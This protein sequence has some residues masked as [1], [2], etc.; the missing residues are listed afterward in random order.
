MALFK[1][2]SDSLW[3]YVSP[4]KPK[5]TI[6]TP[7]IARQ[8]RKPSQVR[9]GS[10]HD[11]VRTSRSMSPVSRVDSWRM[12]P[13]E[14]GAS[15]KRKVL[16]SSSDGHRNKIVKMDDSMDYTP[17]YENAGDSDMIDQ[18]FEAE[19]IDIE[20]ERY[21]GPGAGF[22]VDEESDVGEEQISD[23]VAE[24]ED[25][26]DISADISSIQ[27]S[28]VKSSPPPAR[29]KSLYNDE[30][31]PEADM[32]VVATP[33]EYNRT[34]LFHRRMTTLPNELFSRDATTEKLQAAGWDDDH[35]VLVQKLA[36]RGFEP[37]LPQ[38]WKMDFRYL[39]D[40]LFSKNNKAFI[41]SVHNQHNRGAK[42]LAKLFEIGGRLRDG[43][44]EGSVRS[45]AQEAVK[46][47]QAYR[48]WTN[49]DANLDPQSAIPLLSFEAS[50]ADTSTEILISNIH[51][52][53]S[54]LHTRY[55][56]ALRAERS[57]E[58]SP[59]T[60]TTKLSY[61]IPQIYGFIA[62]H[63][64]LVLVAYRPDTTED[65]AAAGHEEVKVVANF[66]MS[67]K[68]YDVWN[69][70]AVGIILCHLRNVQT[71]ILEDTGLGVR[72]VKEEEGVDDPDV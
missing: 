6:N 28:C 21:D 18:E 40:A 37:L 55:H 11:I 13:A 7:Q 65:G 39:P 52:K 2:L 45:P 23:D 58:T 59:S 61:P 12:D 32:P 64:L 3:A 66:D 14:A 42:A 69:A 51:R 60:D 53:M 54:R 1:T 36:G 43:L 35:I 15:R 72:V 46:S 56:N 57:I 48:K 17:E 22:E 8:L 71:E 4:S 41:S 25:M 44:L 24:D 10:Y 20:D 47:I 30:D 19:D 27:V 33:E 9:R 67:D 49:Q 68:D 50:P 63:L 31:D 29:R 70:L 16:F 62:S 26:D 5:A 38:H 34:S